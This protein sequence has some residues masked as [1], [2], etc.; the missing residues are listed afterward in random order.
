MEVQL[1]TEDHLP[2]RQE[3][4]Q[5]LLTKEEVRRIDDWRFA[6]RARS[7]ADA[8]RQLVEKGLEASADAQRLGAEVPVVTRDESQEREA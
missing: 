2:V 1:Q 3:K 4:F 6:W 7:R 5:I 8:V